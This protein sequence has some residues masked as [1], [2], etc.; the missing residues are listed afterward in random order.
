MTSGCTWTTLPPSVGMRP[1]GSAL[2]GEWIYCTR[3]TMRRGLSCSI[4][5]SGV[6]MKVL[7]KIR[8]ILN[9]Y[10]TGVTN[11]REY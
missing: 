6:A 2:T 7:L 8:Q 11:Q 10:L 9:L 5:V 3:G 4:T 1:G